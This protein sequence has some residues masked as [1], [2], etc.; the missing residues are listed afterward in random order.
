MIDT[1][2]DGGSNGTRASRAKRATAPAVEPDGP[3]RVAVYLEIQEL[4]RTLWTVA[5][6]AVLA[7]TTVL[8][9]ALVLR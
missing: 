6:L 7:P 9:V 5:A 3:I 4:R 1:F 8:I 2:H